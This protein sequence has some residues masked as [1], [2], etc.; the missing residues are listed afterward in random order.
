MISKKRKF[1]VRKMK[2]TIQKRVGFSIVFLM[3][4][5]LIVGFLW[6]QGFIIPNSFAA[7]SYP[8]KGIDVSSY[9]GEIEWQEFESQNIQFAFIK[10]TE[11]STFVDQYFKKNWEDAANTSLRIGAY[12]FFSYDSEGK[13][14]AENFIK[15]VPIMKQALPPVIDVEFYGD[16]EK[17]PPERSHV[18][19]ELQ[20]MVN[21]LEE[22]YGK[23]VILYTTKK[24]YDLYIEN[25]FEECDI[26]IRDV[27]TKPALSD[28]RPWTFWQYTDRER[29]EG[30]NGVEKFIDVNVFNGTEEAFNE[31]GY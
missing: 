1:G 16:K 28:N 11:G 19:K 21:I 2:K 14:Q 20:I 12:H 13:T 4:V 31:Y 24:A 18:E 10:A 26:W 17:N 9:Q 15:T 7:K 23:R 3:M 6:Y 30:Y 22:H 8:V 5:L 25:S 29:L 27:Y